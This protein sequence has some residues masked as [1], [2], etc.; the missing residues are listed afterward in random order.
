MV[1]K[2]ALLVC[3][4]LHSVHISRD[5]TDPSYNVLRA[6]FGDGCAAV[7]V[8]GETAE[9]ASGKWALQGRLSH[10]AEDSTNVVGVK[11]DP[12]GFDWILSPTLPKLVRSG[13]CQF[14]DEVMITQDLKDHSDID[15]W[16]VHPGGPAILEAV[17]TGLGLEEDKLKESW[18]VLKECG[19]MSSVTIWNVLQ[20][21][22]EKD[23]PNAQNLLALAFGPGV[24]IESVMLHKHLS[25][26]D[27]TDILNASTYF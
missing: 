3:L 6:I 1:G 10:L 5:R 8:S 18:E 24:T 2:H 14:I 7:V 17:Q 9:T 21:V 27:N 19:N 12:V 22:M 13:I 15:L 11:V 25:P 4:E 16:A 26:I 23:R 20:K